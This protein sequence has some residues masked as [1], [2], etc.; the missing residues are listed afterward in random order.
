[1][2]F[3]KKKSYFGE[4]TRLKNCAS[5]KIICSTKLNEEGIQYSG[6]SDRPMQFDF[7]NYTWVLLIS[8]N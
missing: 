2:V 7:Q 6:S 1:M 5:I 4:N 3:N 8:N